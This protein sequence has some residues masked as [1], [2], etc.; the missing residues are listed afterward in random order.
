MNELDGFFKVCKYSDLKEKIGQRFFV[1]DVDIAVFKVDGKVYALSNMC[2]HQ[3]AA[4][5]YDGFIEDGKVECPAHGWQFDL[6]TGRVP[7]AVAGLDSYPVK[8]LGDEVHIQVYEKK[9]RW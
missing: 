8:I 9:L 7:N 4:I 3:K 1:N 5:I 6:K 2:I